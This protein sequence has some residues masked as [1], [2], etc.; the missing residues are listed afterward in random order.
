MIN[1]GLLQLLQK[2]PAIHFINT[3]QIKRLHKEISLWS[4]RSLTY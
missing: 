1:T 3:N 4:P 2:N